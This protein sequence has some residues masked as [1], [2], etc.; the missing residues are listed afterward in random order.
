MQHFIKKSLIQA[1]AQQVF[2]WHKRPEAVADLTPPWEPV[3]L[4]CRSGGIDE[5]G[6]EVV[7]RLRPLSPV[8]PWI[9]LD[10]LAR[11]EGYIEQPPLFE[12]TDRQIAGPFAY[13]CHTHRVIPE[14]DT[15]CWLVDDITYQVPLTPLGEWI[16]GCYVRHKLNRMFAYRHA[17]TQ[18]AFT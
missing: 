3:T 13:W 7:L 16:G 2:D 4:Q 15:S 8:V 14:N 17:V 6:S 11:H 5:D 9:Y 1:P 18:Q 12:F 10:W